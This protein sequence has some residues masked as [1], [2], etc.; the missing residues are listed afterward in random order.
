MALYFHSED[1]SRQAS[2]ALMQEG[3]FLTFGPVELVPIEPRHLYLADERLVFF[4]LVILLVLIKL[5]LLFKMDEKY[6]ERSVSFEKF[7]FFFLFLFIIMQTATIAACDSRSLSPGFRWD[8]ETHSIQEGTGMGI[9]QDAPEA[10]EESEEEIPIPPEIPQLDQP[11]VNDHQRFRELQ[12]KFQLYGRLDRNGIHDLAR[13]AVFLEKAVVIEKRIEAALVFDGYE[14]ALIRGRISEIRECLFAH[15]TRM[16]RLS[17]RTLDQYLTEIETN[18]TRQSRPYI[19]L[20]RAIERN[21]IIL[22]RWW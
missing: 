3:F 7:L 5:F 22:W 14:P 18:G 13:F 1:V 11:L 12:A 2:L 9:P 6:F 8:F 17:E 16:L 4:F 15:P 19:R 21:H 10:E 20:M